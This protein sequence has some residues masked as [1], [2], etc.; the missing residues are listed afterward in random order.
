[1]QLAGFT[2]TKHNEPFRC[3]FWPSH[4]FLLFSQEY[5]IIPKLFL[6][7]LVNTV[8]LSVLSQE[9]GL[10]GCRATVQHGEQ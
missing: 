10:Q 2:I 6:S 7:T 4:Y 5:R 9:V 8:T 1:V 3:L